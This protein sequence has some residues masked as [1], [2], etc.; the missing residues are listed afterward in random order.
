MRLAVLSDIHGNWPALEAVLADL[1]AQGG[2]DR[3]WVLGDLAM[4]VP[5]PAEVVGALRRLH[6]ERPQ[7]VE[8]IGGNADRYMAMG[9]QRRMR[10]TTAEEWAA[11]AEERQRRENW[12]IY[13]VRRLGW[14]DAEFIQK[15]I[16]GELVLDVPGYG[17]VIGFHGAPGNDEQNLTPQ[18][19]DYELLDALSDSAGRLA[20]GGHT[21]TP[22][23]RD[24]GLWRLVNDGSV[25][26]PYDG[27]WR[28][29]YALA[30]FSDGAADIEIRRV[31]YDRVR[32]KLAIEQS[33]HPNTGHL[34]EWLSGTFR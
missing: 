8:I 12:S 4:P 6:A 14:D 3:I 18:M 20:F 23:D 32:L 30:T 19:A 29:S 33:G 13:A 17:T 24:L 10:P 2:A 25:G 9:D 11:F 5:F 21:H 31:E 15:A 26:M 7:E 34:L 1:K 28:A 16:G 27:D 22:M